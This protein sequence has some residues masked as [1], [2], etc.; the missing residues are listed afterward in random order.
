MQPCG[1][2]WE[3]ISRHLYLA[4]G[5]DTLPARAEQGQVSESI[6]TN[7]LSPRSKLEKFTIDGEP[8]AV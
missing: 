4:R 7:S 8:E 6:L 5:M 2:I 3:L 1:G